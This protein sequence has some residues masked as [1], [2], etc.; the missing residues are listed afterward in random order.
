[1]HR[2]SYACPRLGCRTRKSL[3]N[4]PL[5][6]PKAFEQC[7]G[8][9]RIPG[10]EDPLDASGVHPE[11]YPVVRR[12]IQAAK[13]DIRGL[14]GNAT[15]LR[16]LSPKNFI[17]D[18]FGLPTVTDILRELEKPGRDPRPVFTAAA[19]M[20]GVETLNDLKPGMVVEGAVTNVAAFGAFVDIG[21]HQDGTRLGDVKDLREGY[22]RGGEARRHRPRQGPG[23][24]LGAKAHRADAL[25]GRR[26]WPAR[27]PRGH[28]RAA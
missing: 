17:D 16:A 3:K 27:R 5:L 22:A 1:M 11:A 28:S 15:A 14:M 20:E 23:G 6:G 7:A 21:V 8:F 25:A 9:L 13:T 24:R 26:G 12:I 10:G 2:P 4:V 19:F 18:T